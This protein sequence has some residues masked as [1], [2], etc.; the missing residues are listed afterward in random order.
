[1][2][3]SQP[4]QVT[5]GNHNDALSSNNVMSEQIKPHIQAFTPNFERTEYLAESINSNEN[6]DLNPNK[7]IVNSNFNTFCGDNFQPKQAY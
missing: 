5:G 7:I 2:R 3:R 4:H 6:V 1:M